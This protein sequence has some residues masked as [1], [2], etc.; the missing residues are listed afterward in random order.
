MLKLKKGKERT[1]RTEKEIR[2]DNLKQELKECNILL[3]RSED[4]FR[5]AVDEN[6]IE[7]RIYE[8]KSLAKHR[9]YLLAT[10]KEN[11]AEEKTSILQEQL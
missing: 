2:L 8:I 1:E 3:K 7:A 5:F 11:I 4:N 9:D 10:I 6:L